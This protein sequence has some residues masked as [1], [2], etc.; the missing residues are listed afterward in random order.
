MK[1]LLFPALMAFAGVF[2]SCSSDAPRA[3]GPYN[4]N[5]ENRA[6]LHDWFR[7]SPERPVVVSGHRGGMMTGYPEN[8][9]ESF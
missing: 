8:C 2:A 1:K 6:Q 4:I 7:Y 3:E 9:I 5:I